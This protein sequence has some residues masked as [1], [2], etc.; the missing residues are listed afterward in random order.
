MYLFK[1]YYYTEALLSHA[2]VLQELCM[3]M[4]LACTRAEQ[5]QRTI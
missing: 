2:A 5:L 1:C 3:N 4:S